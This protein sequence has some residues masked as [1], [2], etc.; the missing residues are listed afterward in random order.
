MAVEWRPAVGFLLTLPSGV[1]A[2]VDDPAFGADAV[3]PPDNCHT[4]VVY[5][6]DVAL[7][8]LVKFDV[9]GFGGPMTQFNSVIIPPA[10]SMSFGIGYLGERY[11]LNDAANPSAAMYLMGTGLAANT[12]VNIAYVQGPGQGAFK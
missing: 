11:R 10:S 5:N 7:S 8:V 4:I 3:P 12:S 2:R 1:M 6:M 9:M